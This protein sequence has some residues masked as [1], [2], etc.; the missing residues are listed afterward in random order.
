MEKIVVKA[1]V[2]LVFR[3]FMSDNTDLLHD[4]LSSVLEIPYDSIKNIVIQNPEIFPDSIDNKFSRLDLKMLVDDKIL[5]VEIQTR[6]QSFFIDRAM[7]YWSKLY[8]GELKSGEGYVELKQCITINIVDFNMFDCDDYYSEFIVTE[9]TRGEVLTEKFKIIFL[10]LKKIGKKA[11]KNNRRELWLQLINAESEEELQM[12]NQTGVPEIQ[13]AVYVLNQMS[14]DEKI[15]EAARM[16]EKALHD[17]VSALGEA[18]HEGMREGMEKG[19]EKGME[20]GMEAMIEK[21]KRSGMS[22][23]DINKVLIN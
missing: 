10:E 1:K 5:N 11:N 12:L 21:M 14:K 6:N 4:F 3:K 13:K 20:K 2:D 17:E 15:R 8:S 23:E 16:R 9:K 7:Y 18:K 22:E 19:L